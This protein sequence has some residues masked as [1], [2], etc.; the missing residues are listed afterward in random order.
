MGTQTIVLG[1]L[2]F[3]ILILII[4]L[5][6]LYATGRLLNV[7]PTGMPGPIGPTGP[8]G[9]SGDS[10]NTGATGP[11]GPTGVAGNVGPT[12]AMGIGMRG[13]TGPTGASVG[14]TSLITFNSGGIPLSNH[15]QY[16]G[17]QTTMEAMATIVMN[18][19]GTLS[20]FAVSGI[21][22]TNIGAARQF[23]VKVNGAAT[24]LR[25]QFDHNSP[26]AQINNTIRVPVKM[27]DNVSVYYI[28]PLE[29][30]GQ[31][32]SATMTFSVTS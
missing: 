1:I 30:P 13:S 31:I 4:V 29:P 27:F 24:A 14:S 12:G 26:S 9:I 5:I 21:T 22:S 2:F 17:A 7:G 3:I 28:E 16:Y 25:V 6:I 11:I 8:Q 19:A 23:I 18:R 32:V 10:T 20:N 15:Y